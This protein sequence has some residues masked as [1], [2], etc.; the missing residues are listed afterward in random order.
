MWERV[1][2][3]S[4]PRDRVP[5]RQSVAAQEGDVAVVG[6]VVVGI[7]SVVRRFVPSRRGAKQG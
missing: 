7:V 1:A 4:S 3:A 2:A 5:A 6:A